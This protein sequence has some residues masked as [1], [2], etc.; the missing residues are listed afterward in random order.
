MS[1]KKGTVRIKMIKLG[2]KVELVPKCN[3]MGSGLLRSN[4]DATY[5]RLDKL[6]Y[7]SMT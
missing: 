6:F 2:L 1:H 3:L 7:F 5:S 4:P